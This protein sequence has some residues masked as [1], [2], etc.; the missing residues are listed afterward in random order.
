MKKGIYF[1]LLIIIILKLGDYL[2]I[3]DN[4]KKVDV[5]VVLGGGKDIRT[6]KGEELYN[7]GFSISHKIILTGANLHHD[8]SQKFYKIKYLLNNGINKNNIIHIN[9]NYVTNTM[10]ELFEIKKYLKSQN[11]NS[12]L[13]VTHPSHSKRTKL[14]ANLIAKY[15]ESSID[16]FFVSADETGLW[17]KDFYFLNKESI[18][19][20]ISE[21]L[22]I[23]YNLI[24]Y[25]NYLL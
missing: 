4:P 20:V 10:E 13:I 6:R 16:L 3:T 24:K 2:D 19:L 15:N 8:K 12:V 7:K 9:E 23:P 5:V 17:D 18:F 21:L 22:K 11:Y 1:F 25:F 14:L